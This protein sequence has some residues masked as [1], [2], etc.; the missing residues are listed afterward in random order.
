MVWVQT[1]MCTQH[2]GRVQG[3]RFANPPAC[4]THDGTDHCSRAVGTSHGPMQMTVLPI[5]CYWEKGSEGSSV[6]T[7]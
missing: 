2:P 4:D 6:H 7:R 3:F 1:G 5:A